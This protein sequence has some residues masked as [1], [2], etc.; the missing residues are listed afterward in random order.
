MYNFNNSNNNNDNHN[1]SQ[2]KLFDYLYR[3]IKIVFTMQL[4]KV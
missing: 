2:N 1:N 4:Y 3:Y